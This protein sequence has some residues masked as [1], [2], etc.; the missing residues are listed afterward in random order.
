MVKESW[1]RANYGYKIHYSKAILNLRSNYCYKTTTIVVGAPLIHIYVTTYNIYDRKPSG[2][3]FQFSFMLGTLLHAIQPWYSRVG[4]FLK[5]I[6]SLG[7]I[8]VSF[9]TV[10][11]LYITVLIIQLIKL[12]LQVTTYPIL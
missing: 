11:D 9:S 4:N 3:Y 7:N 1:C 5:H 12:L 10:H 6:V 8:T 2:H